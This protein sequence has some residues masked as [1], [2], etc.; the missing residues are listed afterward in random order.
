MQY[1]SIHDRRPH[2]GSKDFS[3]GRGLVHDVPIKDNV[4]SPLTSYQ[5]SEVVLREGRIGGVECHALEGLRTRE[6]L[7]RIPIIVNVTSVCPSIVDS[8]RSVIRQQASYSPSAGAMGTLTPDVEARHRRVETQER[9]Y[10]LHRE[11]RT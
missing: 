2:L 1:T 4:V 8:C 10:T 7:C 5:R 6:A 3:V 11:V 9:V